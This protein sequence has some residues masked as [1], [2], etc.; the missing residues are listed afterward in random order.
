MI[1]H[2]GKVST[3]DIY[4]HTCRHATRGLKMYW[5]SPLNIG[6]SLGMHFNSA[7]ARVALIASLGVNL[8]SNSAGG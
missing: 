8:F 5:P 7:S 6:V 4:L 1:W 2:P 3:V